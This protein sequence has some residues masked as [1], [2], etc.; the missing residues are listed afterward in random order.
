M[1]RLLAVTVLALLLPAGTAAA[2]RP[3]PG[4]EYG[5]TKDK[6]TA[7]M[8]KDGHK[9][10]NAYFTVKDVCHLGGKRVT[11]PTT[12]GPNGPLKVK[13]DGTFFQRS[14]DRYPKTGAVE[15]FLFKGR[16]TKNGWGLTVTGYHTLKR[17]DGGCHTG[18]KTARVSLAGVSGKNPFPGPWHATT[19]AGERI[20]FR[21]SGNRIVDAVGRVTM[22]CDDGTTMVR[23]LSG[24]STTIADDSSYTLGDRDGSIE[25]VVG[26]L[27]IDGEILG[28]ALKPTPGDPGSS[29]VCDGAS[30]FVARPDSA[31]Q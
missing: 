17:R 11:Y 31:P 13:A 16:F 30:R 26:D 27:A 6:A 29:Y 14:V 23:D 20:T 2:A 12:L 18:T 3:I 1:R 4:G 21:L 10:T 9:I 22:S 5:T 25:G 24:L 28:H 7:F 8:S 15:S 19:E